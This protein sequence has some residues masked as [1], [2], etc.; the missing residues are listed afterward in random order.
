MRLPCAPHQAYPL[1]D[2]IPRYKWV[3]SFALARERQNSATSRLPCE[4]P[5]KGLH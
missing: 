3:R 4:I 2:T 5:P 1:P